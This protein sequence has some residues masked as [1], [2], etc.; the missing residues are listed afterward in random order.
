MFFLKRVHPPP[1]ILIFFSRFFLC[2]WYTVRR[3][4]HIFIGNGV[5]GSESI[6]WFKEDL[7]FSPQ[8]NLAPRLPP[9][10]TSPASCLSFSVFLYVAGR[11][12]WRE[13][14]EG[15]GEEPNQTTA[16]KLGSSIN[17]SIFSGTRHTCCAYL[18]NIWTLGYVFCGSRYTVKKFQISMCF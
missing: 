6:E 12:Y 11:A 15:V 18:G 1:I 5:R 13:S 8:Y 17:Y 9:P 2:L 10:T 16:R 7:A 14:G 3:L 4:A